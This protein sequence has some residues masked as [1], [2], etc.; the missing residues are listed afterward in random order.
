MNRFRLIALATMLGIALTAPAQQTATGPGGVNKD[1]RGQNAA[2]GDMPTVEQQLNVLTG[3]LSLTSDQQ[4]RIKPIL[5][6]LHDATL[7][8]VEDKS[9][10]RDERLAKVR[11]QR[12]KADKLIREVLSE[13]QKKSLDQYE[14]GPH[15]EMHGSLSGAAS[16][17][18]AQPPQI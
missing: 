2:R 17:S 3:K 8:I 10:S 13:D 16:S 15:P 9:L 14:Q 5:Q 7:K 11:P 18:T 12:Y 6:E 1:G 4:A